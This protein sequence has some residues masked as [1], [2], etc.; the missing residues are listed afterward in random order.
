MQSLVE[1]IAGSIDDDTPVICS[2]KRSGPKPH[3]TGQD[4]CYIHVLLSS[5]KPA[6]L[7]LQAALD[8]AYIL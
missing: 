2:E 4:K 8:Y 5:L 1:S 7:A 6:E 3:Q